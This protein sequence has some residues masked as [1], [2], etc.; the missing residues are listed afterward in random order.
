MEVHATSSVRTSIHWRPHESRRLTLHLFQSDVAERIGVDTAS[1]QHWE[2]TIWKPI[3][4]HHP[5]IIK[6][7][8][9][10]PFKP[11][12]SRGGALRHLRL[13]AGLSQEELGTRMWVYRK[14]I[15]AVEDEPAV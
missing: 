7:L 8:E 15:V 13:C 2:R 1:I 6:F 9:Y 11:D 5:A 14:H 12:G 4:S 3:P 10:V